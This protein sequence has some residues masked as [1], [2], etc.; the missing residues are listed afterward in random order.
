M[1]AAPAGYRGPLDTQTQNTGE[2]KVLVAAGSLAIPASD[3]HFFTGYNVPKRRPSTMFAACK[4][5]A[6]AITDAIDDD[7]ASTEHCSQ[8]A[9][10]NSQVANSNSS[11][12]QLQLYAK[13]NFLE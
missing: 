5:L 4:A 1:A 7:V 13:E 11:S 8:H 2:K 6:K 12:S 10:E 3:F 9:C